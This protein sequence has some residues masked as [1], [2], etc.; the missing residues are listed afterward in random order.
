MVALS[1]DTYAEELDVLLCKCCTFLAIYNIE[2][3]VPFCS[4][5]NK[6]D[7]L[8]AFLLSFRS[9]ALNVKHLSMSWH[10]SE[11]VLNSHERSKELEKNEVL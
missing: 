10:I 7:F 8:K 11:N 2:Q 4:N 1:F 3:C 5:R 9:R 6:N